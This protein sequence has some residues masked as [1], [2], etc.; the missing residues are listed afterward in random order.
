MA[1]LA[2]VTV[3]AKAARGSTMQ[4]ADLLSEGGLHPLVLKNRFR[5]NSEDNK[6]SLNSGKKG[7]LPGATESPRI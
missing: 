3:A 1:D 6:S 7:D 2:R 4:R 5:C